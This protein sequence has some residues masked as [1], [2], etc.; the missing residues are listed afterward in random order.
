MI[1][2]FFK[3]CF[4]LFTCMGV[5]A[6]CMFV[7]RMCFWLLWR[8]EKKVGYPGTGVPEGFELPCGYWELIQVSALNH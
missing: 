5:L 8:P 6:A 4:I 7:Y 1:L 2:L 3:L